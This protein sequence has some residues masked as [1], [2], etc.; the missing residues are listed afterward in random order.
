MK[1]RSGL[2][3]LLILVG[4]DLI[5]ELSRNWNN[6]RQNFIFGEG[7]AIIS[8]QICTSLKKYDCKPLSEDCIRTP[9]SNNL[10]S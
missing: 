3:V 4:N 1:N 9:F 5:I 8:R 2:D 6:I 7:L 10:R